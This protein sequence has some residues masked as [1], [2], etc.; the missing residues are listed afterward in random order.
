MSS[1]TLVGVGRTVFKCWLKTLKMLKE[2]EETR[3]SD[4]VRA[5]VP[6]E[7][8]AEDMWR[9]NWCH[10]ISVLNQLFNAASTRRWEQWRGSNE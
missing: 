1:R 4:Q 3:R 2:I 5:V 7:C 8:D 10:E 6:N 9:I